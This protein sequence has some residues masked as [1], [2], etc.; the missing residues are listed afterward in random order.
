MKFHAGQY[1]E[2][3]LRD[4]S[5]RS[6]S[7][8][9]APHT[10]EVAPP[11]VEL[12]IRHMPGG[13]FTDPVFTTMKEKDILRAEGPYGS[14][15]LREDSNKPM[16][17]LASGT[18][19]APIK[20]LIEHMQHRGISRPATLYWGGR[21]PAD[22]YMADW[23]EARLAEMPNLRYVPVISNAEAEDQWTGRTG[24]VHQAVLQDFPDLSGH[25]VYACGAPIVV[26]SAKRDYVA[27]G[28]LPEEEFY[29]DSFTSEAD[30]AKG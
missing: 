12:H 7:M 19:F 16:V 20:A 28:H 24:F 3:L 22:L 2:F 26:D 29:A 23:V 10:L 30:K 5:R 21:R 9:N 14:F 17:L 11:T 4:G 27:L 18:G 15:Y 8:A 1:I 13:K 25:Q 6:Y